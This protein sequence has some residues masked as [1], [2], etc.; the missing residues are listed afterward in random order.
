MDVEEIKRSFVKALIVFYS[1]YPHFLVTSCSLS[2]IHSLYLISIILVTLLM[3]SNVYVNHF[4]F[5]TW[6]YLTAS[7]CKY[8]HI[9]NG[10]NFY[11]SLYDIKAINI[12]LDCI[13][14]KKTKFRYEKNE[15]LYA[16]KL[17]LFSFAK[18]ILFSASIQERWWC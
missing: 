11:S 6:M 13:K 17:V 18:I 7:H 15:E 5:S 14:H 12:T 4:L 16:V 10:I 1:L 3:H 9:L 2:Y 8:I